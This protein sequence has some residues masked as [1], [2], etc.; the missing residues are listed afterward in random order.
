MLP[1]RQ[2]GQR[3][4]RMSPTVDSFV[5]FLIFI[6]VFIVIPPAEAPSQSMEALTSSTPTFVTVDAQGSSVLICD[7]T[8]K[9]VV[10]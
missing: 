5:A 2:R 6:V 8:G 7:Y 9:E 3:W 1:M 10:E 4:R